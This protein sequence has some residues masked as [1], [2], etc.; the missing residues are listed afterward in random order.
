MNR[1]AR[2]VPLPEPAGLRGR[3]LRQPHDA[4]DRRHRPAVPRSCTWATSRGAGSTPTSSA[5][6]STTTWTPASSRWWVT[7]STSSANLALG[8]HLYHGGWSLF[9]SLG[10]N[11]PRFNRPAPVLRRSASPPSSWSATSSFRVGVLAGVVGT[12]RWSAMSPDADDRHRRARARRQDP[13][14]PDRRARGRPTSSTPSWSTRPT[15]ASYEIIVVGTGLAGAAAAATLAELGYQV[16]AF[17]FHD[18]PRRAH[19][20]AAQGGINAAKNYQGDGDS[21]YRLFY[22]TVKGGDFRAREANVYRL[23]EV[24][25]QHHRPVRRPGRALRPRVRRPARQPLLRRRAGVAARSTPA[26]RPASSSCSAP[27]RR[28]P[29]QV[30]LGNVRA[31]QPHARWSTSSWSTGRAPAS[32]P[33]TC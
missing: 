10:W 4:L 6:T 12:V 18:S 30:G 26:A 7:S 2:P 20:I 29:A 14:R 1:K 24:S 19:S 21:I 17:T 16:K 8:L 9:Q 27:T 11:N 5:A 15:S 3:Q 31:L 32:S 22:D 28:W 33:A 25:G 13:A 23:A